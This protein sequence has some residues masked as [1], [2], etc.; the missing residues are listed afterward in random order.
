MTKR[1]SSRHTYPHF[2]D[3]RTR[4]YPMAQDLNPQGDQICKGLLQFH[5]A[6]PLGDRG[7]YWLKITLANTAGQDKATWAERIAWVD[8]NH[9]MIID[10]GLNPLDGQRLWADPSIDEPYVFLA[11]AREYALAVGLDN[12]AHFLSRSVCAMD[13]VCNGMQILSLLGKDSVGA[14][15]TNCSSLEKRYDLYS[16]IKD[17]VILLNNQR[18]LEGREEAL[19]WMGKI[20]RS[21]VKRATMTTPYG[22][23]PRGIAGQLVKDG[24]CDN[25]EGRKGTN[26]AFMRDLIVDALKTSVNSSSTI[27]EYFQQSA[28]ALAKQELPLKWLTPTGVECTQA[29]HKLRETKVLT[30]MGTFR[31]WNEDRNTG[32]DERKNY[33]AASPNVVHSFDAGLLHNVALRLKNDYG[34]TSTAFIHDSYGVHHGQLECGENAVDVLHKVIREE[35]HKIFKGNYLE[36]FREHILSYAPHVELPEAPAQGDFNVDELLNSP[37]FFS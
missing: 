29:Y 20:T 7:L 15:K 37:Y 36:E 9:D 5:H 16:E 19:A 10:S 17:A 18:A 25:I 22:V 8:A 21:T 34:V 6:K 2:A 12:P 14:I 35:A 33:L 3:F 4:L 27:M 23:T 26:A 30:L 13:G 32:L 11:A 1:I 31:L 24:F 28:K